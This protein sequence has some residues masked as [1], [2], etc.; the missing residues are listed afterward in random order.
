MS[1]ACDNNMQYDVAITIN[2]PIILINAS[3]VE[4]VT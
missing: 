4:D 2:L 1:Q 3:V